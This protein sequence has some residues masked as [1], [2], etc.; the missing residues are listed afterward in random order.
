MTT[1]NNKYPILNINDE[2]II[3]IPGSHF[4]KMELKSR[5]KEMDIKDN[6]SQNKE[7]LS[8]LYDS[9][10]YDYQNCLKIIQRLRKDTNSIN[11]KLNKSQRQSMPTNFKSSYNLAESKIM[12]ISND[13]K[14]YYPYSREQLIK[15]VKPMHT[16]KGKYVQN[17]FLSNIQG[18][19]YNNNYNNEINDKNGAYNEKSINSK[20]MNDIN[21]ENREDKNN[22]LNSNFNLE[23]NNIS[24]INKINN[25]SSFLSD[26]NNLFKYKGSTLI[27]NADMNIIN[28]SNNI[29]QCPPEENIDIDAVNNNN[30]IQNNSFNNNEDLNNQTKNERFDINSEE[31]NYKR[32]SKRLTYQTN[33]LKNDI[34]Y[35]NSINNKSRKTLTNMQHPYNINEI[36]Y[37]SVMHNMQNMQ[38]NSPKISQNA[39]DLLNDNNKENN[40]IEKNEIKRDSDEVSTFSLFSAFDQF[41]KYPIYKNRKFIL[42]HLLILLSILCL[43]ISLFNV[44]NNSWESICALFS[45]I[46]NFF[47]DPKYILNTIIS[48]ISSIFLVPINYWYMTIPFVIITV[49]LYFF[50]KRYLFKKRCEEILEKI[51]KDLSENENRAISEEDLC[52]KYSKMYGISYN[53]FI[54]KYL[55]RLQKLRRNDENNRLKLSS[56]NN[57]EKEYI[58]WELNQ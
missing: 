39:P 54:K 8:N 44:I 4:S 10:L 3:I 19:N 49:V 53:K 52:I 28:K 40:Y 7:Y 43:V 20:K 17:P 13:I 51:V 50:V 58:F 46:L 18:Q 26:D 47:S 55:P 45:N 37:N 16:N 31:N 2:E 38:N 11:V 34:N 36:P 6:N 57:N 12:N 1:T 42:I 30:N 22:Y 56:V 9:S 27:L 15:I 33:T 5:L 24:N 35:I 41:K 14:D 29:S 25:N 21:D 32:P 23:K 48:Y